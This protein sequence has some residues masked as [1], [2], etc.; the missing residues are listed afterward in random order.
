M[1]Y[2]LLSIRPCVTQDIICQSRTRQPRQ[3]LTCLTRK[4]SKLQQSTVLAVEAE[5]LARSNAT[6]ADRILRT[7]SC[8]D[9]LEGTTA[10]SVCRT[11][12][13]R[14]KSN[15]RAI[16]SC[17]QV[18]PHFCPPVSFV[19]TVCDHLLTTLLSTPTRSSSHPSDM[20]Y[21]IAA[22]VIVAC[23]SS[24]PALAAP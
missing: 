13:I 24:L 5:R 16:F 10:A 18:D 21:S 11:L 14:Y 6:S 23:G 3:W 4:E 8:L 7:R 2:G 12:D 1:V 20:R 17:P 9:T 15:K 22:V 19:F